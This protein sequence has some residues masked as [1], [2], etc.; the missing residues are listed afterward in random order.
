MRSTRRTLGRAAGTTALLLALSAPVTA[1]A[2]TDDGRWYFDAAGLANAHQ[3]STGEGITIGLL[4]TQINP[5]APDLVGADVTAREPS[6]CAA[7]DGTAFPAVSTDP[8]ARHATSMAALMVGT[9]AGSGGRPGIPGVAPGASVRA[10]TI[11]VGDACTSPAGVSPNRD[12]AI[13]D[14]IADGVDIIVVPG[15]NNFGA[16]GI[17]EALQAGVIVVGAGGNDTLAVVEA[18]GDMNGVVATGWMNQ[19]GELSQGS[20]SGERLGVVAPGER[21][22]GVADDW[23]SYVIA[24]GSSNSAAFTAGALALAWSAHPDATGNQILQA[25]IHTTDGEVHEPVH[26]EDWGY[27]LVNVRTLLSVDPTTYPDENPFLSD[28]PVLIPSIAEVL[29]D[30]DADA[31]PDPQPSEE[32]AAP[33]APEQSEEDGSAD[34]TLVPV[35]VGAGV[36]LVL[37]AGAA[38]AV[39][40]ARR[41]RS[42]ADHRP[43]HQP[44]PPTYSGGTHG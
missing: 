43:E 6:Y 5:A 31:T 19:E 20:S 18:P 25:L 24:D 3:Q 27:G 7:E 23:T 17:T 10:Y 9:D 39:V 37:I 36:A 40:V 16:A 38:T 41:R 2:A 11:N 28:N 33:A 22:R 32:P 13:R 4:D 12:D 15:S 44:Q 1:T 26:D 42:A 8:D 21:M 34:G 35:L 30:T 29:G 14:A